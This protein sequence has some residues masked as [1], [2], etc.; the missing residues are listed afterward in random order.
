MLRLF[1][2]RYEQEVLCCL[3]H[4]EPLGVT[5]LV[6]FHHVDSLSSAAA[7][8]YD[9]PPLPTFNH[10]ELYANLGTTGAI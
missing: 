9:Y 4:V 8:L 5:F 2:C 3:A 6:V 1:I 10:C 7:L